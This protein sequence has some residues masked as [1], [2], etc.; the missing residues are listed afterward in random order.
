MESP[1]LFYS[2]KGSEMNEDMQR[3]LNEVHNIKT[4]RKNEIIYYQ[5]D[6]ALSFYYLKKGKVN[7]Y[8]TSSDGMEKILSTASHGEL[9]GEGAFFD[10]Q[11]RVS[12]ARAQTDS[13]LVIIDEK[14]LTE[15]FSKCPR[16]AL[17]MLKILSKRIRLLS[18]QVD[19]MTFMQ[20]DSRIAQLLLDREKDG[21][22]KLTHEEIANLVGATRVTV[23]KI[24][25]EFSKEK[26][27]STCYGLIK[28]QN[29]EK[30][31]KYF[32]E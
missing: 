28:I 12:S 25:G 32:A 29:I 11:P 10:K 16:L 22:V 1:L 19:A 27:V 17:E 24:L 5:G 13:E 31:K 4:F 30:L 23:S 8:M 2:Q 6:I 20:T 15:L 18:Q 26:I 21:V 14:L 3:I 9:L 7:V